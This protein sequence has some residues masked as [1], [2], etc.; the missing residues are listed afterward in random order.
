MSDF[1]GMKIRQVDGGLL[2]VFRELLRKR[3]AGEAAK[4]LNLSSSAISHALTRLRALF[5]DPLFVRRPHGLEPTR[6]ALSLAPQIEALVEMTNAA[7]T[8]E[9]SFDPATCARRFLLAAPDYFAAQ[10]GADLATRLRRAAPN[11]HFVLR[12]VNAEAAQAALLRGDLDLAIGRFGRAQ[13]GVELLPLQQDAF[14]VVARRDHPKFK[15]KITYEQYRAAR[16]VFSYGAGDGGDGDD[17]AEAADL[18]PSVIVER[19][20][21]V[22]TI[23]ARTDDLGTVP[24]KLAEQQAGMLG[25][26]IVSAP[27]VGSTLSLSAARRAGSVDPGRDWFLAQ[28]RAVVD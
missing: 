17:L 28:I 18:K 16:H 21:T 15:R 27:F 22:L 6:R 25:L 4:T 10:I 2:L 14:C 19:W 7:L 1:D 11:A 23:V 26:R 9:R 24:R 5:D 20:L 3:R 13:P 12:N 8:S